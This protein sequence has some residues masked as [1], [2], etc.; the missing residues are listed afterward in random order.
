MENYLK[1][2]GRVFLLTNGEI[3]VN[4]NMD[5]NDRVKDEKQKLILKGL[6]YWD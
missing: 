5:A 2:G 6:V 3:I 4:F 1:V